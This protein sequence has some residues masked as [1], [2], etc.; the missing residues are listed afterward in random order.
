MYGSPIFSCITR[1]HTAIHPFLHFILLPYFFTAM[2]YLTFLC[3]TTLYFVL[4]KLSHKF[5]TGINAVFPKLALY[6][7][8]LTGLHSMYCLLVSPAVKKVQIFPQELSSGQFTISFWIIYICAALTDKQYI[9]PI[10][11]DNS[12]IT[13]FW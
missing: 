6:L 13:T 4:F 9:G 5:N 1:Q 12:P 2:H 8:S 3:S 11:Q 10:T 7:L